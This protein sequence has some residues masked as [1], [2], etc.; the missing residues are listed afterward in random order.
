M[1]H[2]K[3]CGNDF[4]YTQ[5]PLCP[6]CGLHMQDLV[7]KNC[8]ETYRM[9]APERQEY[10]CPDCGQ[11]N[12]KNDF[13]IPLTPA[14][15]EETEYLTPYP[16]T[17]FPFNEDTS[18]AIVKL[19][20]SPNAPYERKMP[21]SR[22]ENRVDLKE[23]LYTGADNPYYY[24]ISAV[25]LIC[26]TENIPEG[27]GIRLKI[28]DRRSYLTIEQYIVPERKQRCKCF[29]I[30]EDAPTFFSKDLAFTFEVEKDGQ[31]C[32]VLLPVVR[33]FSS[34]WVQW[35]DADGCLFTPALTIYG[36]AYAMDN[37]E[38]SYYSTT[39]PYDQEDQ[40]NYPGASSEFPEETYPVLL[41]LAPNEKITEIPSIDQL[42]KEH[43]VVLYDWIP[44]GYPTVVMGISFLCDTSQMP[45]N[46]LM[47]LQVNSTVF[48]S[49]DVSIIPLKQKQAVCRFFFEPR[50]VYWYD[51]KVSLT[52]EWAGRVENVNILMV[53]ALRQT[54][55]AAWTSA[56]GR[57][58][59]PAM[60]LY[61]YAYNSVTGERYTPS[62]ELPPLDS[63]FTE[64]DY[65][66][67]EYP[68]TDYPTTEYP[69][70]DYPTTE[71]A[72][73][74]YSVVSANR[75]NSDRG[76]SLKDIPCDVL[77]GSPNDSWP[78]TAYPSGGD[79]FTWGN[80]SFE[81]W[82]RKEVTCYNSSDENHGIFDFSIGYGDPLPASDKSSGN[83]SFTSPTLDTK[84]STPSGIRY[85]HPI[86]RRIGAFN[87][88]TG[89]LEDAHQVCVITENGYPRFTDFT[90]DAEGERTDRSLTLPEF[91]RKVTVSSEDGSGIL[92]GTECY[93]ETLEDG[94]VLRYSMETGAV[95]AIRMDDR[96]WVS[97]EET[98]NDLRLI[99]QNA[100]GSLTEFP[101]EKM[102]N[103]ITAASP[104]RS[105]ALR[106]VWSRRDGLADITV[107][108]DTSYRI[109]WYTAGQVTGYNGLTKLFGVVAGALP[110]KTWTMEATPIT[111]REDGQG[112]KYE[113]ETGRL[114]TEEDLSCLKAF[115]ITEC[116]GELR[117]VRQWEQPNQ[118]TRIYTLGEGAEKEVLITTDTA[119]DPVSVEDIKDQKNFLDNSFLKVGGVY[120]HE[121]EMKTVVEGLPGEFR[122][123]Y[124]RYPFGDVTL[125]IEKGSGTDMAET[126]TYTYELD[127]SSHNY[128]CCIRENYSNGKVIAYN[129]DK[130]KRLISRSEPWAGE[131]EMITHFTYCNSRV[132]DMRL[133]S[134]SKILSNKDGDFI[135]TR[136]QYAFGET[137]AL[138][139]QKISQMRLGGPSAPDCNDNSGYGPPVPE[140]TLSEWYG[141]DPAQNGADT[142]LAA[143][144]LKRIVGPD[145][146]ESRYTYAAGAEPGILYTSTMT[147][148][149][150]GEVIPHRSIRKV[151][152]YNDQ[153]E[154]VRERE[155]VHTGLGFTQTDEKKYT[156][157]ASRRVSRIDYANGKHTT[158]S[159]ICVGPLEE[160]DEN[161]RKIRYE[162]NTAKRLKRI[163]QEAMP[164]IA[165]AR[166]SLNPAPIPEKITEYKYDGAGRRIKETVIQGQK[167]TETTSE[168]DALGRTI[169]EQDAGGQRKQYLYSA[170]GLETTV[171]MPTGATY[172]WRYHQNGNILSEE[173]TGQQS[174]YYH[175][176]TTESGVKTS[177]Y[178]DSP[179]GA[180]AERTLTDGQG[181]IL[182]Q[183][184]ARGQS[185]P[186]T[187]T[188]YL[189]N[190]K[191]WRQKTE[192]ELPV[193]TEYDNMGNPARRMITFRGDTQTW[194][195]EISY[196]C[197]ALP[198]S[199][200]S[201]PGWMKNPHVWKKTTQSYK[202]RYN[203]NAPVVTVTWELVSRMLPEVDQATVRRDKSGRDTLSWTCSADGKQYEYTAIPE[204]TINNYTLTLDGKTRKVFKREGG[205]MTYDYSFL[206]TGERSRITDARGNTM[207]RE[208][209]LAG[210]LVSQTDAAGNTVTNQYD[211]VT[212]LLTKTTS[213]EGKTTE[214]AYD[215]RGNLKALFG[216]AVQ[217][218]CCQYDDAGRLLALRTFR[219]PGEVLTTSP[220]GRTDGDVTRWVYDAAS[221]AIQ[222]KT[223]PDG[224]AYYWSYDDKGRLYRMDMPGGKRRIF[225]YGELNG[226]LQSIRFSDVTPPVRVRYDNTGR[227]EEI[228]DSGGIH[229]FFYDDKQDVEKETFSGMCTGEVRYCWNE[230]GRSRGY[231][232]QIE[233]LPCQEVEYEYGENQRINRI[234]LDKEGTYQYSWNQ[235]TGLPEKITWPDGVSREMVYET[236]RNL[237]NKLEYK[238][239]NGSPLLKFEKTFDSQA[240]LMTE[241]NN[242]TGGGLRQCRYN[243]RGEIV[244]DARDQ[245]GAWTYSYDNMGNFISST[246][247]EGEGRNYL[248]NLLNQYT[249]ITEE[250]T[251]H[252]E[253][254]APAYDEAGNQTLV[255][256]ETG[257][258]QVTWNAENRPLYFT[259]GM[260]RVECLYDYM[261]RRVRKN[262][263]RDDIP[264]SSRIYV[265]NGY[266]L[267]AELDGLQKEKDKQLS[268]TWLW[269]PTGLFDNSPLEMYV[270]QEETE[271]AYPE[272]EDSVLLRCPPITRTNT[273]YPALPVTPGEANRLNLS[274]LVPSRC[275]L[276][277]SGLLLTVDTMS[278][279]PGV[280]LKITVSDGRRS[281]SSK[282][283]TDK[284]EEKPCL[285]TFAGAVFTEAGILT[286]K[287]ETEKNGI[288]QNDPIYILPAL[289]K[290]G[291]AIWKTLEANRG[292]D[293]FTP[294][295]TL[296]GTI[297][298]S[299]TGE[300]I[301][302]PAEIVEPEGPFFEP[303][304]QDLMLR[305]KEEAMT[306]K[307]TKRIEIPMKAIIPEGKK[308]V[309]EQ[310]EFAIGK[311]AGGEFPDVTD[312]LF[313]KNGTYV[314]KGFSYGNTFRVNAVRLF[315]ANP[316]IL[317]R[318]DDF[319][320]ICVDFMGREYPVYCDSEGAPL[321]H[322]A[323]YW[324]DAPEWGVTTD[325]STT[326]YPS[327]S[328]ETSEYP[329]SSESSTGYPTTE[330]PGSGEGTTMY[331]SSDHIIGSLPEAAKYTS[332]RTGVTLL[333]GF[334]EKKGKRYYYMNDGN[335]NI[336]SLR[337]PE[338]G[339][340]ATYTYG[341]YGQRIGKTG[342]IAQLNPFRYSSEY[343]DK[344]L[345]LIYYNY[346]H[347]NPEDGRW[348]S[349]DP[350][351]EDG[352][353]NLYGFC[354]NNPVS[355]VDNLGL[356]SFEGSSPTGFSFHWGNIV[357]EKEAWA[358][359]CYKRIK[360]PGEVYDPD[361]IWRELAEANKLNFEER[362]KWVKGY[363]P[364][365]G[366]GDLF[367]VPNT[368]C[369]YIADYVDDWERKSYST[370][371]T[372]RKEM[373]K[374]KVSFEKQGVK[375]V[376][377]VNLSDEEAFKSLWKENGIFGIGF[378]GHGNEDGFF[379]DNGKDFS[380]RPFEIDVNGIPYHLAR[381]VAYSC[382]SNEA[383]WNQFLS[384]N[385]KFDGFNGS[386]SD[387]KRGYQDHINAMKFLMRLRAEMAVSIFS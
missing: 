260:E 353:V 294:G 297:T 80:F 113:T 57:C 232:L 5:S 282:L 185:V 224:E 293:R 220:E 324:E 344:E 97:K 359:V 38:S 372:L 4:S 312:V 350:K 172:L 323:G 371:N 326:D 8:G 56:S 46:T 37:P 6:S 304:G 122:T 162:Y 150:D 159:W 318:D 373:E 290:S 105:A 299:L 336:I 252:N 348:L 98:K 306:I 262:H 339:L 351:E 91:L 77:S 257:D 267:I 256:T 53:P 48:P 156:Y 134:E 12:V 219:V 217:P 49:I 182:S 45:D 200:P 209:D 161:G 239:P 363:K 70:T 76:V 270:W 218:M 280:S 170:D 65:P 240:R 333:P 142:L 34:S 266:Q 237:I 263:Y 357:R 369:I 305:D 346:R 343:H 82:L 123:R 316:L 370:M 29:F 115:R 193:I 221:G 340:C 102:Y 85:E 223:M 322:A 7:C 327:S 26:N 154:V 381:I 225:R 300:K 269:D 308:A 114:L 272:L 22:R 146:V 103:D 10:P 60:T 298:N 264:V 254:F 387:I 52:Y 44:T 235:V 329:S 35:L 349:R 13:M 285:F 127:S 61:G 368:F 249:A 23:A 279:T 40:T 135:V 374:I 178:V 11:G 284:S 347:Y 205:S 68:V 163:V 78:T 141:S 179:Y 180:L 79:D 17:D 233:E 345:G 292:D 31:S 253:A 342:E 365:P 332:S 380:C 234:T 51:F 176:R 93:E 360:H 132:N 186:E 39:F 74:A 69:T 18:P 331:A 138:K 367:L 246:H 54:T 42:S 36:M 277:L 86:Q 281:V 222:S 307:M 356:S 169:S 149:V 366:S 311:T 362:E 66:V 321:V 188:W 320:C 275:Q 143:G 383:K 167:R 228:E 16:P 251:S 214:Y 229:S 64:T 231:R 92:V 364:F 313:Y 208:T 129:Y 295:I 136:T 382:C 265:Y 330:Y 213:P 14:I 310:A 166:D 155:Y 125:L 379:P 248:A 20:P 110:F 325:Y 117:F 81:E 99:Y 341:P 119:T 236:Q 109:S 165:E 126:I 319:C 202:R 24:R 137:P 261:G 378:I 108:T 301:T 288:L 43:A 210:R 352:G 100:D 315:D 72:V 194:M 184:R 168:L 106:Q 112:R 303:T 227:I 268:R 2:C 19:L 151:S 32:P 201:A 286:V 94:T 247:G 73:S 204:S 358:I 196:T 145:G 28:R 259:K 83:L 386:Y 120:T 147:Q 47:R 215:D 181:R 191:P 207:T 177:V 104:A 116:R 133:A 131:G 62:A 189:N 175:Y 335:R 354:A 328:G 278:Y 241:W 124:R 302:V 144:R 314:G 107:L 296:Y 244:S 157:D 111:Y 273:L 118:S 334:Q 309:I 216:T 84:F 195:T 130:K 250:K 338:D 63:D 41:E 140:V 33:A 15:F 173:G 59:T 139:W 67:T 226:W 212:G 375:I 385:G 187:Q 384:V 96:S 160:T 27:S 291:T 337:T 192:G 21:F 87:S 198:V 128:G 25:G 101:E 174:R 199:L 243:D 238:S 376:E 271:A 197:E 211:S 355:R 287:V 30:F 183:G 9:N 148:M 88:P 242:L 190:G 255:R 276:N 158:S 75:M 289:Q 283:L 55:L 50:E 95:V 206:S 89:K 71:Y 245:T 171:L 361:A 317:N 164:Y 58:F 274:A 153:G 258:W 121:G 90:R 1:S 152:F 203:D 230:A 377:K 3:N